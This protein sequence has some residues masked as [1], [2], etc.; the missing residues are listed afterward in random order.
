M[1]SSYLLSPAHFERMRPDA[2]VL[3]RQYGPRGIEHI[4]KLKRLSP[5]FR[6]FELDDYLLE[7]PSA[8][9]HR[10]NF[11]G[12][13]ASVLAVAVSLCDRLVVSTEPCARAATYAFG[14]SSVA[15]SPASGMVVA[16]GWAPAIREAEG[17][18]GGW[19]RAW[20]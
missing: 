19:H 14:Y 5:A 12:D 3:Q 4:E 15:Q 18:L 8:S 9:V 6:V 16:A 2:V 7:L 10:A 1:I 13:I 17:R 11:S 20:R